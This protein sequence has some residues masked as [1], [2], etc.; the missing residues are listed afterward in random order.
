M[1]EKFILPDYDGTLE[2][3]DAAIDELNSL[4]ATV[5]APPAR[6]GKPARW[7]GNGGGMGIAGNLF[8]RTNYREASVQSGETYPVVHTLSNEVIE[9]LPPNQRPQLNEDQNGI[10]SLASN[11]PSDVSIWLASQ[12]ASEASFAAWVSLSRSKAGKAETAVR[13]ALEAC[14][15]ARRFKKKGW[16]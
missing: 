1:S 14:Q 15:S 4:I 10:G 6:V 3:I 5:N 13:L 8:Q 9:D 16:F 7:H 2:K 11:Y 12:V